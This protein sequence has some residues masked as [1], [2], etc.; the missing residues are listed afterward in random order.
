MFTK[1]LSLLETIQ[2]GHNI[3][4]V[5]PIDQFVYLRIVSQN[6]FGIIH[7][8]FL[9]S[10]QCRQIQFEVNHGGFYI[11]VAQTVFYLGY[12][13]AQ[14]KHSNRAG[15]PKAVNRVEILEPLGR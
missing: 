2:P 4:P 12:G 6:R 15:V 7:E 1:S 5:F 3:L 10:S 8:F 11:L 13:A 14:S 9:N